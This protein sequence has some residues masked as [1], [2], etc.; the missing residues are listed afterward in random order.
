MSDQILYSLSLSPSFPLSRHL[1]D[2]QPVMES[3]INPLITDLP[4]HIQ[5]IFVQ[6]IVKLYAS[7]LVKAEAEVI[8][9]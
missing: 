3:L 4:G 1:S 8:V 2:P 7:I 9:N 6:N 5:A